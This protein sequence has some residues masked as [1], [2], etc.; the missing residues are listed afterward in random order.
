MALNDQVKNINPLTEV[1]FKFEL[2]D[3]PAITFFVQTVNLPGL[4][5]DVITYGRPQRTGLGLPGGGVEYELLE[6]GFVVD[7]YLK[8]WQEI[9]NWMTSGKPKYS[10]AILTILSS[11][12]NPTLEVHFANVFPTAL[13]ELTFDSSV[14]ETTS[15]ISNVT[16]NYTVFTIK[17]LLNN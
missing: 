13:T 9:F 8:N 5:M 10:S 15:L 3:S 12:M 11:S 7:E 16:F 2:I 1:Q 4:T 17:N 6:V 14:S